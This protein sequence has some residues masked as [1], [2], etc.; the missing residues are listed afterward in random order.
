[1]ATHSSILAWR[2]PWTAEPGGLQFVGL[3]R[4]DTTEQLTLS[5]IRHFPNPRPLEWRPQPPWVYSCTDM[6]FE[7]CCPVEEKGRVHRSPACRSVPRQAS[8]DGCR[9]G[10]SRGVAPEGPALSCRCQGETIP[11]LTSLLRG[12]LR[13]TGEALT[14]HS[15]GQCLLKIRCVSSP[16]QPHKRTF[17]KDMWPHTLELQAWVGAREPAVNK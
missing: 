15:G 1:M 14:L 13:N 12:S 6:H 7:K 11:S 10:T 4:V 16:T 5:P 3:Q 17:L 8:E 2:P 9:A